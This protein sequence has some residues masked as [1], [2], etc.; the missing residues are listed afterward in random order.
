MG[1]II[2]FLCIHFEIFPFSFF[3]GKPVIY[4]ISKKDRIGDDP[5][6]REFENDRER[7]DC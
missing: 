3:A 7:E 2:T 5:N 1:C 6:N 4:W